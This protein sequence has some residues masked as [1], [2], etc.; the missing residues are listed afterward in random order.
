M[1]QTKFS[2]VAF[3]QG[4]KMSFDWVKLET[5]SQMVYRAL[6]ITADNDLATE[7]VLEAYCVLKKACSLFVSF[8]EIKD[9]LNDVMEQRAIELMQMR[10]V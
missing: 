3:R 1:N 4:D 10:S 2:I 6:E 9:F 8:E 5:M 7:A